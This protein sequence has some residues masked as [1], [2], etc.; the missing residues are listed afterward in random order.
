[1]RRPIETA[2]RDGTTVILEDHT[3]GTYELTRWSAQEW[4]WVRKDGKPYEGTPTYWHAMQR[5]EHLEGECKSSE[6][7]Q[8]TTS[9]NLGA[10]PQPAPASADVYA[11]PLVPS[12]EPLRV[13]GLD[14]PIPVDKGN[15]SQARRRFAAS[16]GAAMVAVSLTGMY[17]RADVAAYA[18]KHARSDELRVGSM[19]QGSS[20]EPPRI[21]SLARGPKDAGS[22]PAQVTV[23]KAPTESPEDHTRGDATQNEL[24]NARQALAAGQERESQFKQTAETAKTELQQSLDKIATLESELALARQQIDQTSAP[25][26]R[27]GRSP[28]RRVKNPTLEGFFG[29][30][31]AAP[32]RAPVQRSARPR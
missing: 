7:L 23:G 2:P 30:F 19:P 8:A 21:I 28:Q 5:A 18:A 27:S 9:P 4:A 22:V 24:F 25:P 3:K 1:M 29:I 17:F 11:P 32:T 6:P 16:C 10:E 14:K 20:P 15:A 12:S 31:N 13:G 26:R